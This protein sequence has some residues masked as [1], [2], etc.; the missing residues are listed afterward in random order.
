[1]PSAMAQ[2]LDL[3]LEANA[4]FNL[5]AVR[6][7]D[8]AWQRLILD[9]LTLREALELLPPGSQV[10]DVGTGGGIPGIP[11][12]ISLPGAGVN[13]T[14][15]DAT[16]KKVRFLEQTIAALALT[17]VQ[18]IQDRAETLGQNRQH[19]QHY[20]AAVSRAVGTVSEVLEYTLPL[21]KV[22]GQVLL[23]KGAEAQEQLAAAG[24]ALDVLG[25]G[26]VAV[27]D[28]YPEGTGDSDLVIISVLKDRPT[29]ATYPRRPGVPKSQP[30]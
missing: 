29:P 5:T 6:D 8:T 15:L 14:L 18:A 23:L 3:L 9:S 7:R 11:L 17:N 22:G 25:A 26:D 20:D 2:Y 19:R 10:I 1:M 4:R 24:D 12:A 27:F 30:L 16:G 21:V 28:A 13:F